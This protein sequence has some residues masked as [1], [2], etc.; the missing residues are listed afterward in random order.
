MKFSINRLNFLKHLTDV[1]RAISSKT[2]IPILTGIKLLLKNDQ[3]LL[4]GSDASISIERIV[5]N[6]I[7]E[8]DLTIFE[9]GQIVLPSRFFGE[10]IK[11][12]S[13]D[14]VTI[15]LLDNNKVKIVSDKSDFV[16]NGIDADL[17]PHIQNI[18][19]ENTN[20]IQVP[21][22]LF[23]NVLAQTIIAA[24]TSEQRPILTGI[25][26][27]IKNKQLIAVATDSHR[28]SRRV[29]DL[30]NIN[31]TFEQTCTVPAKSLVELSRILTD[32]EYVTMTITENKILF[33][34][35]TLYFYSRLLEGMY[36]DVSRLLHQEY[37]YK[38]NLNASQFLQSVERVS[39][40]S[41]EGKN[42][43]ITLT[44]DSQVTLSSESTEIGRVVEDIDYIALNS[45]TIKISFNPH[46][47]RDSLRILSGQDIEI[48][49]QE[50]GKPFII[51]QV[52]EDSERFIQ[53]I[54]PIRTRNQ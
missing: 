3:L 17:Y 32:E 28:M 6:Q 44:I 49:L 31:E 13:G 2:T 50:Q 30:P 19:I 36:P 22:I 11:K 40:L 4:T 7:E 48:S 37:P 10:I 41:A 51:K 29:V 25:H 38:I 27:T 54:T 33:S 12:L 8:N 34:T 35:D 39:I 9:E 15:T 20:T 21:T 46:Y 47:M 16:I 23:K 52:G 1:Q 45:D 26:F 5:T 18:D 24:S 42:D 43:F 53:L 14:T